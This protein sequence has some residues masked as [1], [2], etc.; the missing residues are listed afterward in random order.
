M[1][2]SLLL[3]LTRYSLDFPVIYSEPSEQLNIQPIT[4]NPSINQTPQNLV[5]NQ[6]HL[7][8]NPEINWLQIGLVTYLIVSSLILIKL[9]FNVFVFLVHIL[10]FKKQR[11]EDF[12]LVMTNSSKGSFS[13]LRWVFVNPKELT[14]KELESII[15]HEKIHVSQHHTIDLLLI[16]LL[17]AVMWFNPV[18]WMMRKSLQQLHEYLADEGVLCAGIDK[19]QY[20]ALLLNQVAEERLIGLSSNFNHSLIK[21]RIMMMT[22]QKTNQKTK[23]KIAALL[24]LAA[25]LFLAVACVNGRNK[26]NVVTAVEPVRM[27][28]LYIGVDNPIKIAA[29]G[30]EPSELLVS[31]DNGTISGTNGEYTI[32]PKQRGPAVIT[33][34]C[35]GKEI[36]KTTFRVK[37]IPDPVAKIGGK[38]NDSVD[39]GY[40]L[41]QEQ[42][43]ADIENFDFD[44]SFDIVG[45][46]VS[47]YIHKIAEEYISESGKITPE[48]RSLIEKLESGG[49]VYFQDIKCK[50][51][52][53]MIRNLSTVY[54]KIK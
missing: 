2:T 3:P 29:S 7:I 52:D 4:I 28:V 15:T 19:L 12:T 32:H 44:A 37:Y 51:S 48:Q 27:N 40:L 42:V 5:T 39:K 34:S 10:R 8:S 22:K 24:P 45:F 14:E 6:I 35:K 33:V 18:V 43:T 41:K 9:V 30:Y 50:G 38:R 31:I 16:E 11:Y 54:F 20:Q 23:L 1:V 13:F 46:T 25:I 47:A 26:T 49:I 53:G 21:K 17:T 36:Q